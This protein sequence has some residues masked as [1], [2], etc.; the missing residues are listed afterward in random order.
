MLAYI[1]ALPESQRS[2]FNYDA[3][4]IKLNEEI[5]R[6]KNRKLNLYS[7]MADGVISKEEY[8]EFRAGYDR[9][10]AACQQALGK[11][12]EER[13]QAVDSNDRYVEWIEIFKRYGNI[14]EL[15]REVIVNLI[16]RIVVYDSAHIEIMFRYQDELKSAV[17]YIDRF[18]DIL[19]AQAKE[20]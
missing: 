12:Q 2:I 15:H 18:T 13:Q 10:I 7:D 3:Q 14:T 11:I 19:P 4:I 9:K 1:A 17:Q 20:A 6:Y 16:E 8:M 5:E